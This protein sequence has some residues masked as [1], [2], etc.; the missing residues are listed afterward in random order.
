M[1]RT[2]PTNNFSGL[3]W[4]MEH[5]GLDMSELHLYG[6]IAIPPTGAILVLPSVHGQA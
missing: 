2:K 6:M 3:E 5:F 4:P 1:L